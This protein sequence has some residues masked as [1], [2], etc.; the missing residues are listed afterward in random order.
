MKLTFLYL[1]IL[2]ADCGKDQV[3]IYDGF[4]NNALKTQICN[5]SKIVEF[6]SSQPYVRMKYIGKSSNKYRG[7]HAFVTFL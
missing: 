7:F 1:D 2:T 3:E 4:S 6:L 5:G